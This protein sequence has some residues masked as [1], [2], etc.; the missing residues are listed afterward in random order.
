MHSQV[1]T[2]EDEKGCP[3]EVLPGLGFKDYR[4]FCPIRVP[5]LTIVWMI[6]I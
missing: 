2:A 5:H 3:D 4:C 1:A 6:R